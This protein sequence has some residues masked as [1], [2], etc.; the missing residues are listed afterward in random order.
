MWKQSYGQPMKIVLLQELLM[1]K[2]TFIHI[3]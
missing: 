3:M 1:E 2:E